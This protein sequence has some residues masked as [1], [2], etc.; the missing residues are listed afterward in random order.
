MKR[1]AFCAGIN[2]ASIFPP[3]RGGGPVEAITP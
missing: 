3:P 2:K 1:R